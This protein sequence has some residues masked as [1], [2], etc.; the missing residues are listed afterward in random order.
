MFPDS[1]T[2]T[3]PHGTRYRYVCGCRCDTCRRGQSERNRRYYEEHKEDIAKRRHNYYQDHKETIGKSNREWAAENRERSV[4]YCAKY[5]AT[6]PE[7]IRQATADY[8][9]RNKEAKRAASTQ[10]AKDHPDRVRA[11]HS[12]RSA[13]VSGADGTHTAADIAAQ[14]TR[15][16]GLCFWCGEKVSRRYHVDHVI[17]LARGGSN[18]PENLVIS[19]ASCNSRKKSHHP[20][21]FAGVMF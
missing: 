18:N 14:R 15:Q 12:T 19:C 17:P 20:M 4:Q 7:Q 8:Y 5:R 16:K 3:S 1:S 9:A 13:L 2:P 10:Y 11:W 6:H 21:D